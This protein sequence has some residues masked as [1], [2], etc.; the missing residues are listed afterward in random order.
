MFLVLYRSSTEIFSDDSKKIF[1][2]HRSI[3][4]ARGSARFSNTRCNNCYVN[5]RHCAVEKL[6][7]HVFQLGR[8]AA[9]S[10]YGE[11]T[12]GVQTG[13]W[14][15]VN[16]SHLG[17]HRLFPTPATLC[18]AFQQKFYRW[19]YFVAATETASVRRCIIDA[20]QA[21]GKFSDSYSND[22]IFARHPSGALAKRINNTRLSC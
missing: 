16:T 6:S 17:E 22:L 12:H 13:R 2:T 10:I 11:K 5:G 1:L 21:P 4:T 18:I 14:S 3:S 15:F 8:M 19:F 7:A 9:R 20:P